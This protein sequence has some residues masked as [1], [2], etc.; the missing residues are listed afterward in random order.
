MTDLKTIAEKYAAELALATRH[1]KQLA[2]L[3][4][5]ARKRVR[6]QIDKMLAEQ[7]TPKP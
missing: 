2:D 5:E 6:D 3:D 4:P 1:A 7:E